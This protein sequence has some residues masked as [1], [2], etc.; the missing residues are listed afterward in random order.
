[1][2]GTVDI[3]IEEDAIVNG[4][5]SHTQRNEKE[6]VPTDEF[7]GLAELKKQAPWWQGPG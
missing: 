2:N 7:C 1:M 3:K 6:V 4:K 5:E